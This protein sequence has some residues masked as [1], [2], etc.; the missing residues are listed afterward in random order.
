MTNAKETTYK[1][2]L[3]RQQLARRK[4]NLLDPRYADKTLYPPF[5]PGMSTALYIS[6]FQAANLDFRDRQPV[7]VRWLDSLT[8]T[9][10][11]GPAPM[12]DPDFI[13]TVE[14]VLP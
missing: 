7:S 1:L 8:F 2:R 10:A 9:H 5:V 14:E 13:E 6:R 12:L 4:A 11:S 3:L